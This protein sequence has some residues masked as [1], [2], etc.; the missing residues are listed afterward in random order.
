MKDLALFGLAAVMSLLSSAVFAGFVAWPWLRVMPREQALVWL[1]APHM[2][3]RFIGLSFLVVGVVSPSLPR[4]F[5]VSA[6]YGD[7]AA[8][9]LAIVATIALARHASWAIPAAWI[10]NVWGAADFLFAF[11]EGPRSGLQPGMLGA[12]YFIPTT[13]VPPLLVTHFLT[14]LLLLR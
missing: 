2:F 10:F 14:F 9:I 8:G 5:A 7:F 3:L 12:A 1:V 11:Y 13:F 6:A 4:A